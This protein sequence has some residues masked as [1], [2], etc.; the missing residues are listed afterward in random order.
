MSNRQLNF[1]NY[2]RLLMYLHNQRALAASAVRS[3]HLQSHQPKEIGRKRV[4]Y[5][6]GLGYRF[7]SF[8][9]T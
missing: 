7:G 5:S 9:S 4:I 6:T 8:S 1:L 2:D 3:Q